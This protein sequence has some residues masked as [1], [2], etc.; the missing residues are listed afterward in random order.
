MLELKKVSTS[1]ASSASVEFPHK[2][3]AHRTWAVLCFSAG[4]CPEVKP[5][6]A[7]I[8]PEVVAKEYDAVGIDPE[9]AATSRSEAPPPLDKSMVHVLPHQWER[10]R[11]HHQQPRPTNQPP[12]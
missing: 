2:V 1:V 11:D 6:D 9:A 8:Q 5:E 12:Q 7:A 4:T 3:H 10:E